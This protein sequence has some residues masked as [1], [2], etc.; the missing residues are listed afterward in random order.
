MFQGPRADRDCPPCWRRVRRSATAPRE[1]GARPERVR[2][3]RPGATPLAQTPKGG[4]GR[5]R[6]GRGGAPGSAGR[7]AQITRDAAAA[8]HV[9]TPDAHQLASQAIASRANAS[10]NYRAI[11][12]N[13]MRRFARRVAGRSAAWRWRRAT[14]LLLT[15]SGPRQAGALSGGPARRRGILAR[16]ASNPYAIRTSL[17]WPPQRPHRRL[18]RLRRS[19][20]LTAL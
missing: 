18:T 6:A 20:A 10:L 2:A 19:A 7:S 5:A 17:P 15:R 11:A 14:R 16:D 13:K 4:R 8:L 12:S 1:T 3:R 9:E